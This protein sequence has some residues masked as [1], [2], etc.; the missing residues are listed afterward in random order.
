MTLSLLEE[1]VGR[2]LG[3][4][5]RLIITRPEPIEAAAAAMQFVLDEVDQ[6]YSRFREDSEL[7]RLNSAP[8][9]THKVSPLL[10]RALAEALRAARLTAGAVDPTVGLALHLAG[11]DATFESLPP[12][13]SAWRQAAHPIPGWRLIEFD[14]RS[15]TLLVPRGVVIDLGATGKA[16]AAD[17][18]AAAVSQAIG[19]EGGVLVSLGGDV[20]LLGEAPPGGWIIQVG[21]NSAAPIDLRGESISLP[22]GAIATSSTTVRRWIRGEVVLHHIIDPRTG[23]PAEGPWRTASVVAATCVDANTA[24][25]AAIVKGEAAPRWLASRGLPARLVDA[26]GGVTRI[27]GWPR[28][29]PG[30]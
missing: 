30:T 6:T 15:R 18:A 23:L 27:A 10:A 22:S 25:T 28:S 5:T 19:R 1:R 9:R 16:L 17:L 24:A 11:Y 26:A 3:V 7:S 2:A 12:R 13:G 4:A 8:G 29:A 20:A 21:E 14:E